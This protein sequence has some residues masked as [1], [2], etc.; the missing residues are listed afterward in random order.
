MMGHSLSD[1]MAALEELERL[2]ATNAALVAALE[3][4]VRYDR[5]PSGYA[6]D[7][8]T[9]LLRKAVAAIA[10]AKGGK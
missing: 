7:H 9:K 10:A 2:R 5:D 3:A 4:L 6:E 8:G 1:H